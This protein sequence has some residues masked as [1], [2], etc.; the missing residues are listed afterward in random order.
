M[1]IEYDDKGK[2]FTDVISKAPVSV[3]IQ[4]VTQRIRGTVHVHP[5]ERLKDELDKAERFLAVT[6]AAIYDPDGRV[7]QEC[8]F[9][10]V[11]CVQ[12]IWVMPDAEGA[13]GEG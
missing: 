4:T 10:A 6:D 7:L 3:T 13:E 8:P 11:N 1:K 5:E 2:Y 12:I 9:L